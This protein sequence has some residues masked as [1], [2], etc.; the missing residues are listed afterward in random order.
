[1]K[2]LLFLLVLIELLVQGVT[3][4]ATHWSY[5]HD[6]EYLLR[7]TATLS[8]VCIRCIYHVVNFVKKWTIRVHGPVITFILIQSLESTTKLQSFYYVAE[9]SK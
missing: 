1:M 6:N 7:D 5:S 3:L 4:H 8:F 2:L 9:L